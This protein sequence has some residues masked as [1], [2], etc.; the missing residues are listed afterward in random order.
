[1]LVIT[2]NVKKRKITIRLQYVQY[3]KFEI[4]FWVVDPHQCDLKVSSE[5]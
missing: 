5:D 4:R 2:G 1:M 3:N